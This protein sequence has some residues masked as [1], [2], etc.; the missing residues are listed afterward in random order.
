MENFEDNALIDE[1]VKPRKRFVDD[2]IS[3]VKKSQ[4]N[5]LL[6]HLNTQHK[7]IQFTME[8]EKDGSLPFRD[9]RFT[10]KLNSE[11]EQE[12]YQTKW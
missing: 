11:L 4:S 12:V 8:E 10:W 6:S 3:V 7:K 5:R 9:I 2:I 1:T